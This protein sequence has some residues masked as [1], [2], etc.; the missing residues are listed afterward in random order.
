MPAFPDQELPS[1]LLLLVLVDLAGDME[2]VLVDGDLHVI[3][4]ESW[5]LCLHQIVLR[6]LLHID[7]WNLC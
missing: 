3:L 1:V 7:C 4:A 6:C 5:K 2:H